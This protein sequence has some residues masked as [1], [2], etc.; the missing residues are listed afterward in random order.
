MIQRKTNTAQS[1]NGA[2]KLPYFSLS[3]ELGEPTPVVTRSEGDHIPLMAAFAD[4]KEYQ[5][6]AQS[7]IKKYAPTLNEGNAYLLD[8]FIVHADKAVDS[9]LA[10]LS[11]DKKELNEQVGALRIK[12]MVVVDEEE[13]K[14]LRARYN[15]LARQRKYFT[16]SS[17]ET[18]LQQVLL[19]ELFI[20]G[21][22]YCLVARNDKV[23]VHEN[24]YELMAK[25]AE[26]YK[27]RIR[28]LPVHKSIVEMAN[29]KELP[30][31]ELVLN[32][33]NFPPKVSMFDITKA[34]DVAS[35]MVTVSFLQGNAPT[36]TVVYSVPFLLNMAK[37]V[38][39]NGKIHSFYTKGGEEHVQ[40]Y[41]LPGPWNGGC[42]DFV[43]ML[44]KTALRNVLK[45]LR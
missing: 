1:I 29:E 18:A 6:F 26:K 45:T 2:G 38:L 13:K 41:P 19:D 8:A 24:I 20:D 27:V 43:E 36:E 44:K 35:I 11:T 10:Q 14:K 16:T 39:K 32:P 28:A 34:D 4:K 7:L 9:L 23:I 5:S 21:L 12:G 37:R 33:H 3:E 30:L 42:S 31:A 25:L 22:A 15:E 17:F 40:N